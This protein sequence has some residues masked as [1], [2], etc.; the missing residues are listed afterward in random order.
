MVGAVYAANTVGAI[1]GAVAFSI[2]VIPAVGTLWSQR[3]LI[4][5]AAVAAMLIPLALLRVGI[6]AA[7]R[8]VPLAAVLGAVVAVPIAAAV[9]AYGVP[10]IPGELYAFGR[11]IMSPGYVPKMLY[12]GE[13][14]NAS[15]A[16]S[17]DEDGIRYFHV[18]GKTE[19]G[20]HPVD[21]RLRRARPPVGLLRP[22]RGPCSLSASAPES[23]PAASSPIP[24][25]SAS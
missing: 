12:V 17:E 13:G 15:A 2:I 4:A 10:P 9:L 25:S 6:P 7:G 24:R 16:V 18:S 3:I 11:T 20:S 8:R 5:A 1:I 21:M 23:R 14:M 19:A 22:N